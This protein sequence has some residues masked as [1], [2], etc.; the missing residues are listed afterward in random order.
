ME[1]KK[2]SSGNMPLLENDCL[3]QDVEKLQKVLRLAHYGA[4]ILNNPGDIQGALGLHSKQ[5]VKFSYLHPVEWT[6]SAI[7]VR[8]MQVSLKVKSTHMP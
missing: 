6:S 8:D 1:M 2:Y 3:F 4:L 5:M 7:T